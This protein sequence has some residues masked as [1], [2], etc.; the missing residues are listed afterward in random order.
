MRGSP[1]QDGRG[2]GCV[3]SLPPNPAPLFSAASLLV[4]LKIQNRAR[5]RMGELIRMIEKGK[6]GPR[7]KGGR[8]SLTREDAAEQAG[9]SPGQARRQ[10]MAMSRVRMKSRA[11][12]LRASPVRPS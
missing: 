2:F 8:P 10:V 3:H 7:V 12:G 1:G 6:P 4:A 11:D 9:I 5:I